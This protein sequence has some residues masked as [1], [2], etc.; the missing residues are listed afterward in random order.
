MKKCLNCGNDVRP[1]VVKCN[2][3]GKN[4]NEG[5]ADGVAS[6]EAPG[7]LP[8]APPAPAVPSPFAAATPS[9]V[10]GLKAP[11]PTPGAP[12]TT[13]APTSL[14]AGPETPGAAAAPAPDGGEALPRPDAVQ[15]PPPAVAFSLPGQA[16]AAPASETDPSQT[17]QETPPG[18]EASQDG[19]VQDWGAPVGSTQ[20]LERYWAVKRDPQPGIMDPA[21]AKAE[22]KASS[23][24][25]LGL[26]AALCVL[27]GGALCAYGGL[28]DWA[29]P[30]VS[31]QAEE[32]GITFTSTGGGGRTVAILGGFGVL[33]AI[34]WFAAGRDTRK[35]RFEVVFGLIC[36]GIAAYNLFT[37]TDQLVGSLV[38]S[39]ETFGVGAEVARGQINGWADAGLLG[40][41]A[42]PG[43]YIALAGGVILTL[44]GLLAIFAKTGPKATSFSTP[45]QGGS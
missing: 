20:D 15:A 8:G 36:T 11:L 3:C 35:L 22:F 43:L 37:L 4:P 41:E 25:N 10:A 1:S 33:G 29:T 5:P 18:G 13:P 40:V 21:A 24:G 14:P 39:L 45:T 19:P 16:P 26:M 27:V 30:Y 7:T 32:V 9:P 12:Q 38:D 2:H 17:P 6:G 44:G 42:E 28:Q 31:G 34:I 23:G